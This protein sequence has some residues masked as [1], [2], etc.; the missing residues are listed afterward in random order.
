MSKHVYDPNLDGV[1]DVA[2][3]EADMTKAVFDPDGNDKIDAAQI[4]GSGSTG[5]IVDYIDCTD[6]ELNLV[7]TEDNDADSAVYVDVGTPYTI[8]K[9]DMDDKTG[10]IKAALACEI[11]SSHGAYRTD[12]GYN[13]NGGGDVDIGFHLGTVYTPK[14]VTLVELTVGDIIQF[15]FKSDFGVGYIQNMKVT[16]SHAARKDNQIL[17]Y[18]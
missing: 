7:V 9:A 10:D 6:K 12:V 16:Q 1:I 15:R 13:V 8:T 17:S 2:E 11:H 3:T 5:A 18:Y 4:N 14:N